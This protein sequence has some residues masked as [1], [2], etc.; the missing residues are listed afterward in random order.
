MKSIKQLSIAVTSLMFLALN[1]VSQTGNVGIN[2]TGTAPHSAAMLDILSTNK[3][4][5][6][7][8]VSLTTYTDVATISSPTTSL[9]VYNTNAS[10]TNGGIGFWYDDVP[11]AKWIRLSGGTGGNDW[12]LLGNA[13]TTAGTNFLGTTDATD[14][15]FKTN[16]T[17]WMRLTSAG[18]VGIGIVAPNNTIQV[19][20]LIDFNNGDFSTSIGAAPVSS[21]PP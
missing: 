4:L 19:K 2:S 7:P 14:L 16:T 5:L 3:G 18:A 20:D 17:E 10:M 21:R 6:I 9:L 13:G 15:V 1:S 11:S 12:G 8:R